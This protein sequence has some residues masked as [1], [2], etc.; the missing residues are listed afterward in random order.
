MERLFNMKNTI[1][2]VMPCY[3]D[4]ETVKR[5]VDSLLDQDLPGIEVILIDDGSTDNSKT[6]IKFLED[7]HENVTAIYFDKNKGACV[8][9]NEGAKLAK[10]KYLSFLPA[11]ALLY[12]GMARIWYEGLEENKEYCFLY[13]G[14]RI[15][16]ENYEPVD[17]GDLFFEGFDPYMLNVSNYIDGSFPISTKAYWKYAKKMKQPEGL[18]D[19]KIKSLQDWDFWLSVVRN[20]GKGLYMPEI[21]FETVRPHKGGLSDDSHNNWIERCNTIKKKHGIKNSE[22][23]VASLGAGWHGRNVA[24]MM[25]AD[26]KEMPSFKPHEYHAIYVIGFYPNFAGQQDRM[27]FNAHNDG[28]QGRT[29]AKK[30]V[31]FVGSDVWQLYNV[32]TLSLKTWQGYL[33]TAVDEVLCESNFIQSEL[34][35]L[36]IDAKVV[37]IPPKNIYKP[38]ELPEKFTVACYQPATNADFYRPNEMERIARAMPEI[39]FK[40]FGN[41]HRKGKRFLKEGTDEKGGKT[42][43]WDYAEGKPSNIEDMG[44]IE[45]MEGFIKDCSAIMRFPIHDGLPLTVLE[46]LTAARYSVQSVPM[47]H[48]ICVPNFSVEAAIDGIRAVQEIAIKPNTVASE[49]W[50]KE[51]DH[52]KYI[53]TIKKLC[54]YNPK[55][56]WD[57]RAPSWDL[58]A[59]E[60]PWDTEEVKKMIDKVPDIKSVIDMGCGNGKWYPLLSQLGMYTG[61]DISKKLIKIAEK[62]HPEGTF[63]VG[64]VE[65]VGSH[66]KTDLLFSYTTLEHITAKDWPKAVENIKKMGKYLLLIEP[67]GF[68]SRFYCHDHDYEKDFKVIAKKKLEDKTILLCDLQ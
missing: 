58:Q 66:P 5:A 45:D 56:Y 16:D 50:T 68:T 52:K 35:E 53:K 23:C 9:R 60:E 36:G 37:P 39:D 43:V 44:F 21:F 19:P 61:F 62:K 59:T 42:E 64:K 22:L 34:K 47:S 17:N 63:T 65:T 7:N 2:F 32:S 38:M 14:Y 8:A 24:K 4:G 20:G 55:E 26:F 46:F 25:K 30:V 57:K 29:P 10:G 40:F 48:T 51:L 27:F 31:H 28:S 6:A 41:P 54:G 13:G 11:D 12:P 18:W 3:N 67:T 49:Y 1:S 33:R 15:T